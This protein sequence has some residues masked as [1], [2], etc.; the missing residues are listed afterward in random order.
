MGM[1]LESSVLNDE[2]NGGNHEEARA[3]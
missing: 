1:S 3:R 2:N